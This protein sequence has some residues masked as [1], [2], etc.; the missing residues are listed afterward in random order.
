MFNY[1]DFWTNQPN[2]KIV[3]IVSI[4]P[5]VNCERSPS[6]IDPRDVAFR[7]FSS[8]VEF[9]GWG[10]GSWWRPS[11]LSDDDSIEII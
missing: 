6:D 7:A 2:K 1:S 8:E 5:F 4:V 10:D 3:N 11:K 9:V